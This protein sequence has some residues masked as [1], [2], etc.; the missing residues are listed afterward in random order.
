MNKEGRIKKKSSRSL[1]A[2]ML[3]YRKNYLIL[4]FLLLTVLLSS[5][6]LTNKLSS[7]HLDALL[8]YD[9]ISEEMAKIQE[10]F[11]HLLYYDWVKVY[12]FQNPSFSMTISNQLYNNAIDKLK[13]SKINQLMTD[14]YPPK[15]VNSVLYGDV[16][17]YFAS[18]SFC[19]NFRNKVFNSGFSILIP[20]AIKE[21]SDML[22]FAQTPS[23]Y[24]LHV[25]D[26][27]TV[28]F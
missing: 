26:T 9:A 12:A 28:L 14:M 13:N 8:T 11:L 19:A 20:L 2:K 5:I 27:V 22:N 7:D 1:L 10:K 21:Y 3:I 16:C 24:S 15:F 6:I 18:P 25:C 4:V 23:D 17:P